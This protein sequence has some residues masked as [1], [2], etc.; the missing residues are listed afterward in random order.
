M[1][2]ELHN[3]ITEYLRHARAVRDCL[4]QAAGTRNILRAVHSASF[5][6]E[7]R[8]TSYG[9]GEYFVHG[10]GCRVT[11]AELEIDLDFGPEGRVPGFDPWK[12]YNFAKNHPEMYP[13]LGDREVFNKLIAQC[14][15][16]GEL[17]RF[18]M[19]PSQHLLCMHGSQTD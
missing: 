8:F 11:S 9:G 7:G 5:P 17:V 6:R 4:A 18:G 16:A 1:A 12:L 19:N 2:P 3:L 15:E 13:Q 14:L 10:S